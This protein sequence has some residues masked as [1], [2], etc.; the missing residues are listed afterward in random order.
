MSEFATTSADLHHF[1]QPRA[2]GHRASQ[3]LGIFLFLVLF[4]LTDSPL[5]FGILA[6][7]RVNVCWLLSC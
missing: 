1:Q 4:A 7:A 6:Y 2:P 5:V 3:V